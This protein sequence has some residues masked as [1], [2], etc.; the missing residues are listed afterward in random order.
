MKM[1]IKEF[2]DRLREVTDLGEPVIV[3]NHGREIA[4]YL[5]HRRPSLAEAR[6]A[7]ADIKAWQEEM[8]AAGID[9]EAILADMGMDPWGVPLDEVGR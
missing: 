7:A 5:P 8:R 6:K 9:L 1:G 2:R 3:T 4:T